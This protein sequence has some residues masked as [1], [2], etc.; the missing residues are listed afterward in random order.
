VR[1]E[2]F[3][4]FSSRASYTMFSKKDFEASK[5]SLQRMLDSFELDVARKDPQFNVEDAVS[6]MD[7]LMRH[8]EHELRN[9]LRNA[10]TGNLP[11]SLL[12]QVRR[13]LV[14]RRLAH[15][16]CM[17]LL[18]RV[19]YLGNPRMCGCKDV[20]AHMTSMHVAVA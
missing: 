14:T 1:D 13:L 4:T 6:S 18:Q 17:C 19:G 8:Y 2:F 9:P 11:R 15:C 3:E 20:C 5:Q 12:I 7:V 10:L 16:Q